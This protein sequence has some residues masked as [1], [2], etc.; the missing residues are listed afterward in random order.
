MS[1]H[2]QMG[3]IPMEKWI[4]VNFLYRFNMLLTHIPHTTCI[5]N[6]TS[7]LRHQAI[8]TSAKGHG[9]KIFLQLFFHMTLITV[10][11]QNLVK[12]ILFSLKLGMGHVVF[13]FFF[14]FFYINIKHGTKTF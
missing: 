1:R 13:F 7:H 3:A 11:W 8:G 9:T 10:S 2:F 4:L 5:S 6:K 12:P 14:F